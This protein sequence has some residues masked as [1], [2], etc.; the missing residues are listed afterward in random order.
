VDEKQKGLLIGF[1]SYYRRSAPKNRPQKPFI[2]QK[3]KN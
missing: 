3:V 2:V 1:Q